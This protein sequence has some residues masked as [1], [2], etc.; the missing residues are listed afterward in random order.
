VRYGW[1][2][3]ET[4]SSHRGQAKRNAGQKRPGD[5]RVFMPK[6]SA[7]EFHQKHSVV[8]YRKAL[9]ATS[10]EDFCRLLLEPTPSHRL[11]AATPS[12]TPALRVEHTT[13]SR[14]DRS[15]PELSTLLESGT[16]YFALTRFQ[17][18]RPRPE[19]SPRPSEPRA[20]GS[21]KKPAASTPGVPIGRRE[22]VWGGEADG[23][24]VDEK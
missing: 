6:A 4:E 2:T 11:W 24:D 23:S 1:P 8:R 10:P 3:R 13:G 22:R 17:R 19:E 16:F 7:R 18:K 12:A 14:A 9:Q 20:S 5:L 21:V 15:K